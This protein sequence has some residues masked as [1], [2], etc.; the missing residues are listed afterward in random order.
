MRVDGVTTRR[1]VRR[2][3]ADKAPSEAS[4][5][6]RASTEY[7][8]VLRDATKAS[9]KPGN[10]LLDWQKAYSI[11]VIHDISDVKE[12]TAILAFLTAV[13]HRMAPEW[14]SER[15]REIV[16]KEALGEPTPY[17]L[18]NYAV[19]FEHELERLS[20]EHKIR[21]HINATLG[22]RT[23]GGTP[24]DPDKCPCGAKHRWKAS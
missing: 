18:A 20:Q 22:G 8:K 15:R 3:K 19:A 11:G 1:F 10:W 5:K 14:G 4:L 2:L 13:S 23:Q 21:G 16:F 24:S 12:T 17:S 6:T 7:Q 9:M